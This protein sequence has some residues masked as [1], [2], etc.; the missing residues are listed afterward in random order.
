MNNK[1]LVIGA[2]AF[3]TMIVTLAALMNGQ[4]I[5]GYIP[6]PCAECAKD[7]APGHEKKTVDSSFES[8]NAKAYAQG[9]VAKGE[10]APFAISNGAS[11]NAPGQEKKQ[12][13]DIE[14][15]L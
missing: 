3:A 8:K 9:H 13:E 5:L 6:P 14:S 1:I 10:H 15:S 7:Y 4:T 12:I 11:I 2:V